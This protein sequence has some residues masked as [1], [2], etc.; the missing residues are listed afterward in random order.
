MGNNNLKNINDAVEWV[1]SHNIIPYED[2]VVYMENQARLIAN[3][4]KKEKVWLLEHPSLYSA[5]TSANKTDLIDPDKFPVFHS[6]RGGQYTYHGPGQ[7]VAYVMLDLRKRGRDVSAFV[8]N[9]EQW[10]IN[11]LLV[12]DIKTERRSG[13]VG[14]WAVQENGTEEKIAAIGVRLKK[15]ISFHG[16]SINLNPDLSHFEGIVP[17]GIQEF[18]VTSL[19][20][21]GK[22]ITM[23][24][25]DDS[26]K[27]NFEIIFGPTTLSKNFI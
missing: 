4:S 17:C 22:K 23:D 21:L 12:F 16:I 7:R 1:R 18:G 13:R 11:T 26:L 10:I 3:H 2:A 8:R 25:L 24:E 6:G 27:S 14:V 20:R 9:L 5:G 15:W 19:H